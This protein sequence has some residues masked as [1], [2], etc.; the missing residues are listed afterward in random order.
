MHREQ[1]RVGVG[2]CISGRSRSRVRASLLGQLLQ[3]SLVA[4][5]TE[6]DMMAGPGKQRPE[7]A[8]HQPGPENGDVHRDSTSTVYVFGVSASM[9]SVCV[10]RESSSQTRTS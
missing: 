7:F 10:K 6:D 8:A 5:I 2:R 4:R 3:L 9:P 1:D